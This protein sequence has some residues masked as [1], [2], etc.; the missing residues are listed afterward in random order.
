MWNLFYHHSFLKKKQTKNVFSVSGHSKSSGD[1]TLTVLHSFLSVCLRAIKI[2]SLWRIVVI[3]RV[4]MG[5]S[6]ILFFDVLQGRIQAGSD[7]DIVI[8]DPKKLTVISKKSHNSVA[9]FNIFEGMHVRGGPQYVI[10]GG[11]VVMDDGQVSFD[12]PSYRSCR[13]NSSRQALVHTFK[14]HLD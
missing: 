7:A 3:W 6:Q 10:S 1:V 2:S 9:D 13:V 4:P 12:S 5:R 8:W 14:E 11:H